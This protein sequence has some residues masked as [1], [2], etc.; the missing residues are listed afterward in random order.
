LS[1][2]GE[3]FTNDNCGHDVVLSAVSCGEK[4]MVT[5]E[6]GEKKKSN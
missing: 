4:E 5:A 1:K 3:N 2:N 6:I